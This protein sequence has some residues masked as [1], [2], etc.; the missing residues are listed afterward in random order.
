MVGTEPGGGLFDG[1]LRAVVSRSPTEPKADAMTRVVGLGTL[2]GWL[3]GRF[4][5]GV[6]AASL[7]PKVG[8]L[9]RFVWLELSPV[10]GCLMDSF[11]LW[12]RVLPRSPKRTR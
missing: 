7:D 2:G 1:L 9:R 10:A 3:V 5:R 4:G 6:N 12:S 11:A 8:T